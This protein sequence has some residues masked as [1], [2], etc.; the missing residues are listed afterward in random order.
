MKNEKVDVIAPMTVDD[1]VLLNNK[2][3]GDQAKELSVQ[4][5]GSK[6]YITSLR[7]QIKFKP[8]LLKLNNKTW[9]IDIDKDVALGQIGEKMQAISS[10]PTKYNI[11]EIVP[12]IP[13]WSGIN[14]HPKISGP[15][16]IST[17][18]RTNGR[19]ITPHYVFHDPDQR[20]VF[21]PEGYPWR[22]IGKIFVWND[23][24]STSPIGTATGAL[25][26]RNIVVTASHVCPWKN[27]GSWM[28]KFVPAYYDGDSKLGKGVSSFVQNCYGYKIHEA[29]EDMAVLKLYNPLGDT[30]GC[31]GYKTY[32]DNWEDGDYWTKTGY[33]GLVAKGE[34]PSRITWFP[35]IDD[36]DSGE[37]V[38]LEYR[39]DASGGD[40]GGPVF[41]WWKGLPYIIGTHSGGEEEI[42]WFRV[43][44]NNVAAGGRALSNLIGWARKNW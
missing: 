6:L 15:S 42:D 25:V 12:N 17:L 36:D 16:K 44:Q 28:M 27:T 2:E 23:A 20:Q 37:G 40:S 19:R 7:G 21:V 4:N 11:K 1:F 30:L 29:G 32:T 26:G 10:M 41:G 24:R 22:C 35:I 39:V 13:S 38:E 43:V 8:K 3:D 9:E 33:P 18:K 34:R 5:D 31:F 14:Y